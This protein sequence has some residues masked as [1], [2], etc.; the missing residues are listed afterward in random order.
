MRVRLAQHHFSRNVA[1][2]EAASPNFNICNRPNKPVLDARASLRLFLHLIH[3]HPI[4]GHGVLFH[5]GF[6]N[7]R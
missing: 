7:W 3:T 5:V 1:L 4:L 2:I 6:L